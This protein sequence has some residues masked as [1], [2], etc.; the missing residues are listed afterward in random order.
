MKIWLKNVRKAVGALL[1]GVTAAGVVAV[2]EMVGVDVSLPVAGAL[3]V[4]LSTAGTWV[5][6][7]N[8]EG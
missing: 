4:L 6:P 1:G 5:A 2:A 3:A 8:V 7:R